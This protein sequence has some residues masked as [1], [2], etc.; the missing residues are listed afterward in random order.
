MQNKLLLSHR[1]KK[2]G[3]I[4]LLPSFVFGIVALFTELQFEFLSVSLPNWLPGVGKGLFQSSKNNL[5]DEINL[6]LVIIGLLIMCFCAE[7]VEDEFIRHTRLESL[8]WAVLVNYII[9]F[10]TV[11]L[12]YNEGFWYVIIFNMLTIPIIFLLRFYWVL[13]K[14]NRKSEAAI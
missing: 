5:T 6:S 3:L 14:N 12:I 8:Q 2:L 4:I 9:L 13:N 7:K 1:Y 10:F 11:W